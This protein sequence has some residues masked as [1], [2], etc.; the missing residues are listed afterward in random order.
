VPTAGTY[1]R[2]VTVPSRIPETERRNPRAR[3]LDRLSTPELLRRMNREDA[4]VPRAVA[5]ALPAMARAVDAI[6]AR[7]AGGGRLFYVGAGTSGRLAALDAA[8]CPPT[9]GTPPRM[10]QAVV[11][12]G[13][14]A[15]VRAVEGAEDSAVAGAREM[16]R[17]RVSRRDAVVGLTASGTTP[18]VV[19]ALAEARRRGAL[20]VA[21]TSNPRTAATRAARITIAV[22]TGPEMI[23]GS[24]R[25]KAGTA[26][27]L[28][29]NMLSTAV[30][31]R[32]GRAWAGWMTG[33]A[34]TNRK[35]R[36]RGVRILR[37]AT[38]AS[39][40]RAERALRQ[41]GH[42]LPVALVMLRLDI[43]AKEARRRLRRAGGHISKVLGDR[44]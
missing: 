42:K 18:Y 3:G 2:G 38:G 26:Q 11:A 28:V 1:N 44:W 39:L 14:R 6:A 33:V 15:L 27:K 25:L 20:T 43:S 36:A 22:R 9:F 31:V 8:E 10:V 34:L 19:A 30:M 17:R 29:L 16:R 35:L 24:T 7:L 21:V 23:A 32:L 12:G 5:R 41:A 13:F 4:E 40:S 37:E